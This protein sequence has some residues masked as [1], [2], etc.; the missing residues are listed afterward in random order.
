MNSIKIGSQGAAVKL[1]QQRLNAH[2][3]G[4]LKAD[5]DFGTGTDKAVRQFQQAHNLKAD[6]WV[7]DKTWQ[8]LM[9]ESVAPTPADVIAE[10][11]QKLAEKAKAVSSN[12]SGLSVIVTA[13][14][15]LGLREIPDGSNGGPDLA[16]I[17]GGDG[18]PPSAYYLYWGIK[19][20]SILASMPPWCA[21]AVSYWMK[22][23]LSCESWKDTPFET[24]YGGAEQ[25]RQ[26][27]S[28]HGCLHK[29]STSQKVEVGEVFVMSRSG[30]GSDVSSSVS[31]GHVGLVVY[32]D[33]DAVVTIEGNTSNAV[34]SLRRK[35]SSILG[36]IKWWAA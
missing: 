32:D 30:S 13:L 4:P 29:A 27:G 19:D 9:V 12:P 18:K 34:K 11:R 16:H 28:T 33:G 2:G 26:W 15:D 23:G 1:C 21:I 36:F 3:F 24:W 10:A 22:T 6:G 5:G 35:K 14:Q 8:L 25:I 20:A 17:V 31:A 7:G